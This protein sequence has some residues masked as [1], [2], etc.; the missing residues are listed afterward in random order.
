IKVIVAGIVIFFL[1]FFPNIG[2]AKALAKEPS[3]I[4]QAWYS[5]LEWLQD[6]SPEPFGAPDFYYEL[7]ETPF[8]YPETAYGVM[9]WWDYGYWIMRLSHRI[10]NSNPGQGYAAKVARFFIAQDEETA[11]Q[12]ADEMSSKYVIIDHRM[13]TSKFYAMPTWAGRSPDD[14]FGTYYVPKE[15]GELQPVSF[16]YPSY[17]SSTVVRL[18][19]FDGKAMLPEETLVI[20][21]Q[22]KLSQEGVRYKEITGSETFSTYEEAEAYILSQESGKYV[23]GNSNPLVTPVP[24]EKLEHYKLVHQSAATAPVAGKRVPSVKI[25]EYVK[26]VDS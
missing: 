9:S 8:H 23:I 12:I 5:S 13:P 16:F 15:G 22:E 19:N 6:N 18:Y 4:D 25:F 7:Y 20:S 14:Y 24:L 3:L 26:T 1:V 21:Y 10:P 11:N 17:Y 2:K